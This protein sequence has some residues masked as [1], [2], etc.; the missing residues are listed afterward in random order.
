MIK[1]GW[2]LDLYAHPQNGVVLWLICGDGQRVC[3]HQHFPVTFYVSGPAVRLRPLWK[4]LQGQPVKVGLGRTERRDLFRGSIP[5]LSVEVEQP[6]QQPGLFRQVMRHFPDLDAYDVDI[7]LSL[8]YAA[9]YGLFPLA[10]CEVET[11]EAGQV[12]DIR[13][14]DT[15][16]NLNPV[17][18]ALRILT[19][20]PDHNPCHRE[21]E[22]MF[23]KSGQAEYAH[24]YEPARAALLSLRADIVRTDPDLILT[25]WGDT[26]LLPRL[27]KMSAQAGVDL[28]LNR[29][30]GCG[31]ASRPERSY[32]AYGQVIYRGQ[33]QLLFGRWHIDIHNAVMYHDYGLEGILELARVT[34]LAVQTT[35][36][37]SPGTGI[38]SMQIITAL[39]D[40]ILIPWHKQQAESPKTAAELLRA[41]MGGLVFQPIPGLHRDV[42]EIDFISMYPSIMAHFNISPETVGTHGPTGELSRELEPM[43]PGGEAGLVPRTLK[44][45][46]EKRIA[47]KAALQTM[48][49]WH[50]DRPRYKAWTSAHKWLLVTCFGYLGYKNARFGRIEAHEAVT[51]YGREA[52]LR[53]KEAAEDLGF[54]VLHL[55]VD[56]MWLQKEGCRTVQDFQPVLS[57]ILDRTRLPIALDG[58]YKW[59]AFLPSKVNRDVSVANRYFG[60]FQDGEIKMRGIEARRHDTPPFV[61]E[62]QKQILDILARSADAEHMENCQAQVRSLLRRRVAVLRSGRVPLES[63]VTSLNV[64]R[65]LGA[66]RGVSRAAAALAQLQACGKHLRPGQR[67][68]ILYTLGRPGVSAWD[69]PIPP[70]P[71]TINIAYYKK[72]LLE[73]ARTVLEPVLGVEDDGNTSGWWSV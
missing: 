29:D 9:R 37:V 14:K 64:S 10:Q 30:P 21:P 41:D 42:A 57:A 65:E 32:F 49:K 13:V 33:Q 17:Y 38:S 25:A 19:L 43:Q 66:Y 70:D 5:V 63:L 1:T 40:G 15:P 60:V 4:Y 61:S 54:T 55:Y 26:W 71:R 27:L 24:P 39:R 48:P 8:R 59:V 46:L 67:V 69:L 3:L 11:D 45:L 12:I 68:R 62:A 28:P 58:V 56:G 23:I 7:Q 18:P 53:A 73:A 2:L 6:A 35:A 16:W 72:L 52:L 36:R 51:A 34:G 47:L 50:P 31:I 22:R 44:P 20:R